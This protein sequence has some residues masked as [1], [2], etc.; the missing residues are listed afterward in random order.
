MK[1]QEYKVLVKEWNNFLLVEE[2]VCLL[3]ESLLKNNLIN[4]NFLK[5]LREKG[6]KNSIIIP[7]LLMKAMSLTGTAHADTPV[8]T[9]K[10]PVPTYQQVE[11]R[12]KDEGV[13]VGLEDYKEACKVLT[14]MDGLSPD[15]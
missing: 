2:K 9:Y 6:I 13:N 12:G 1:R 15:D 5:R 11:A 8:H 3:E 4:E 10:Q 14:S 7:L